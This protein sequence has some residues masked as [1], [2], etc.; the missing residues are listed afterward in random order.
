MTLRL[1]LFIIFTANSQVLLAQDDCNLTLSGRVLDEHDRS[2]LSYSNIFIEEL[3]T[4]TV[5]DSSGHYTIEGL[6]P[7]NYT[8]RCSHVGCEP[9]IVKVQVRKNTEQNFFPEHHAEL[10][11]EFAID[12]ERIEDETMQNAETLEARE[13]E[14]AA[15]QSLGNALSRVTGVT[16]LSTGNSISKPVIHGLHSNR[17]LILN[18]GVRQEGQQWGNEHA[19][20]IDPFIANKLTVVKGANSVR[21]GPDAIG[22]VIL[23]ETEDL[24]DTFGVTGAL[25]LV[26]ASNGRQGITSGMVQGNFA[27]LPAFSW[28]LQGTLKQ[29]G[30]VNSPDYYLKNTGLKETNFSYALGYTKENMGV[31]VF[32]SQFNTDIG[33]FSAAHIGNLTD[34]QRAFEA[35]EPLESADF[36]YDIERPFQRIAHELFKARAYLHTGSKGE[37]NFVYA[38]QYNR[39]QEYDKHLPRNDSLAALNLPELDFVITTQ[40]G[41][42]IWE[43]YKTKGFKGSFGASGIWQ[44]NQFNGRFFIPNFR[45]YGGGIF[46][47]ERWKPDSA[48]LELEAGVRYDYIFQE[49]FM[50]QND[51]IVSPEFEYNNWSGNLGALYRFSDKLNVKANFGTAW[52]PPNVSELYSDGVHHGAAA[53]EVGDTN[54]VA[55]QAYNLTVGFAYTSSRFHVQLD[56]YYN[57]INNFIYLKPV[58]PPTLTIRGAFPTFHYT[59]VDATLKG[60]DFTTQYAIRE[61]F[62]YT[63]KAS[64]LRAYNETA[65]EWLVQMP[66]DRYENGLEYRIEQLGCLSDVYVSGSLT[67]V[68][69]QTRVPVNSD[70]AAPPEGYNLLNVEAGVQ[71]PMGQQRLRIGVGIQNVMNVAYRDYLN[72]FR[73]YAD[74]LGRNFTVRLTVPFGIHTQKTDQQH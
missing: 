59:Q 3:G 63:G 25:N 11:R 56:A 70:F 61:N 9:V 48:K 6:C 45:K 27:K 8:V 72:R 54:L 62:I 58:L 21:Y 28:R 34:L 57:S 35:E 71:V 30:N 37:L 38:R 64:I 12:G 68:L 13:L 20:E 51:V 39:R 42:L 17:I 32:Y 46:W 36:T 14:Q 15:G 33:I 65:Q 74:E 66:S 52:R 73:Y 23:V 16:S 1:L 29:S 55:E 69:E 44:E 41:D 60:F 50:W 53:V 7:G 67:T 4:G 49:I 18:N 24:P 5:S 26:G 10:L 40:T 2:A 31:E 43:H 19:P 22:G 47:I